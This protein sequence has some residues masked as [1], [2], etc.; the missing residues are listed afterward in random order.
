MMDDC[1]VS[2]AFAARAAPSGIGRGARNIVDF[3]YFRRKL[4]RKSERARFD[5]GR[6]FDLENWRLTTFT[7]NR[8]NPPVEGTGAL[9]CLA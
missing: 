7:S 5:R 6:P 1:Y 9:H 4:K 2:D 8:R 3:I